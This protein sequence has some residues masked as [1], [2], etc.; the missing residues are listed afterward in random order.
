MCT[1]NAALG[2]QAFGGA[3]QTVG[4]YYAASA[5]RAQLKA[6]ADIAD[7][8]A[9]GAMAAGEREEQRLRLAT[10]GLKSKQRAAMGANGVDMTSGSAQQVLNTTDVM[11]EAD[12]NT[13]RSNAIG[14]A[15]GYRTQA[16]MSRAQA[17]GINPGLTALS[18]GLG[19]A[20]QV[21]G[22]WY[23]MKNAGLLT[24]QSQGGGEPVG[25]TGLRARSGVWGGS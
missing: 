13:I 7:I 2:A 8:Q 21:A 14:S 11:G 12:A 17:D 5:Q 22:S 20:T 16:A 10:A 6:Q 15:W 24:Q 1:A 23:Q 25:G 4:S 18:T 3:A 9:R 19:A